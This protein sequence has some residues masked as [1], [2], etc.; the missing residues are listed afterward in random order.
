LPSQALTEYLAHACCSPRASK[1]LQGNSAYPVTA[2]EK[3]APATGAHR[4]LC[5]DYK[6]VARLHLPEP[7]GLVQNDER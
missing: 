2:T 5:P 7:E 1:A 3:T 6:S 4:H